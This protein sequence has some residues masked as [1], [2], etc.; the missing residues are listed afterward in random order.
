MNARAVKVPSAW[1]ITFC[2]V[3][4]EVGVSGAN[5]KPGLQ[6]YVAIWPTGISAEMTSALSNEGKALLSHA[7]T[8]MV[9]QQKV[10]SNSVKRLDSP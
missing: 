2:S 9:M 10:N 7:L 3:A 6:V 1:Q 4:L 8:K 5:R